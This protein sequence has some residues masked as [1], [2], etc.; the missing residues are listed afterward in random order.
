MVF[1]TYHLV[2]SKGVKDGLKGK[3]LSQYEVSFQILP[4]YHNI[5]F[6]AT[7]GWGLLCV[8]ECPQHQCMSVCSLRVLLMPSLWILHRSYKLFVLALFSVSPLVLPVLSF[9]SALVMLPLQSP[10]GSLN[11]SYIIYLCILPICC[12]KLLIKKSFLFN[13]NLDYLW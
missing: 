4:F 11:I 8:N 10:Y 13:K 12:E 9:A 1:R 5:L 6:C 2:Y 3:Q 7:C